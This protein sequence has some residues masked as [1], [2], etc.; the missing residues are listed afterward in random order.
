MKDII[1]SFKNLINTKKEPTTAELFKKMD[2]VLEQ[3]EQDIGGN[4]FP[5]ED[6]LTTEQVHYLALNLK[7]GD[8]F[9]KIKASYAE[10]KK[11]YNPEL[12]KDDEERYQKILELS[13]KLD[14]AYAY[15]KKKFNAE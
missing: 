8:N 15:F 12:C 2:D 10:L 4:F 11:K 14:I 9:D 1:K 13:T 6:T 7:E 5:K 3:A